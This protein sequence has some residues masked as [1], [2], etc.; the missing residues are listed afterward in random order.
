MWAGVGMRICG[1]TCGNG[2]FRGDGAC[3]YAP[4]GS[5]SGACWRG[6]DDLLRA[7]DAE[8]GEDA[9]LGGGEVGGL[10][11]GAGGAGEGAEGELAELV[12]DLVPGGAGGGLGD[13]DEEQGEP[14]ED[15]VGADPLFQPVVDRPQV[16]DLLHVSPAALDFEELPVAGGDVGGGEP[17]VGGAEQVLAVEVLLCP[18]GPGVDAEQPAGGDAQVA[19]QPRFRRDDAAQLGPFRGGERVGAVGLLPE[20]GQQPGADGGV[21]LGSCGVVADHEPLVL[22][23][24]DFLDPQGP[25]DF[26]VA[27]LPGQR[28]G[29]LGGAGAELLADDVMVV[30]AAQVAAVGLRGEAPVGDPHDLRERPVPH[31]V[32]DLADQLGVSGVPGPGPDPDRDPAAGDGHADHDLGQVVAVVLGVAEHAEPARLRAVLAGRALV[33]AALAPVLAAG[34]GIAVLVPRHWLVL[35]VQLEVG[36]GGVE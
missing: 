24:P 20:P 11:E 16:D 6:L 10:P 27:A 21:A 13:P 18:D 2:W 15:D 8:A 34:D 36:A 5:W 7:G 32:L 17:G 19:V 30:A 23:D 12:G 26:L 25:G 4:A 29:G 31:V 14:A 35:G 1:L 22:G 9:A 33:P 28:G 3:H